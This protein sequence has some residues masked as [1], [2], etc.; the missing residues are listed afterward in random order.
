MNK[1]FK[2]L[3]A[4]LVVSLVVSLVLNSASAQSKN[5]LDT[6]KGQKNCSVFLKA[7][8]IAGLT[9]TLTGRGSNHCLSSN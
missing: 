3:G 5:V 7:V 1:L 9:D 6:L 4:I 2:V 8:E